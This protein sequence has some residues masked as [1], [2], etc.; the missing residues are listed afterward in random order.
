MKAEI[1][2]KRLIPAEVRCEWRPLKERGA[3]VYECLH[4]HCRTANLPLYRYDLCD[5]RDR[6]KLADRRHP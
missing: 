4:C 6:R 3:G 2:R 1:E 5:A